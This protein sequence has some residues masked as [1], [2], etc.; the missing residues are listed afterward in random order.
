MSYFQVKDSF[1]TIG[2]GDSN[3]DLLNLSA[4]VS[5]VELN[6]IV[7]GFR[8]LDKNLVKHYSW[9]NCR[10]SLST[11][12]VV[13]PKFI[14]ETVEPI[15]TVIEKRRSLSEFLEYKKD[16]WGQKSFGQ[17]CSRKNINQN[18]QS[19]LLEIRYCNDKIFASKIGPNTLVDLTLDWR[20]SSDKI[21][22]EI[23]SYPDNL[24]D[25]VLISKFV[26]A[27]Q[28]IEISG[29]VVAKDRSQL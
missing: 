4:V 22:L 3:L 23:C 7:T 27:N 24:N 29:T 18:L 10:Y 5:N 17:D 11:K 16:D 25:K 9:K 26:N 1:E 28:S 8:K 20:E 6:I 12:I 13:V 15:C 2:Y 14:A 21:K 19:T